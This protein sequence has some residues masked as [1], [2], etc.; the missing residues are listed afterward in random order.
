MHFS[1]FVKLLLKK[2]SKYILDLRTEICADLS[3]LTY[4]L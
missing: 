1:A 4:H 2:A 3:L